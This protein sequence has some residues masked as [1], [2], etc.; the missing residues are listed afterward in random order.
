MHRLA[1]FIVCLAFLSYPALS[2]VMVVKS[3]GPISARMPPGTALGNSYRLT[4]QRGDTLVL[5]IGARTRELEGPGVF[6][7]RVSPTLSR[8]SDCRDSSAL[9]VCRDKQS[10]AAGVR[11]VKRPKESVHEVH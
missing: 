2:A 9:G 10:Y 5:L 7:G 8:S 3:A 1:K 4:L 6:N 11:R